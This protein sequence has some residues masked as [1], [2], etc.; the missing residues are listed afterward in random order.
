M[1]KLGAVRAIED[2]CNIATT[3]TEKAQ[4]FHQMFADNRSPS[5]IAALNQIEKGFRNEDCNKILERFPDMMRYW[6]G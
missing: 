5:T 4:N 6:N 1:Y 3:L 2:Y